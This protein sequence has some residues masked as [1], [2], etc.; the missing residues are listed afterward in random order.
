MDVYFSDSKKMLNC[1]IKNAYPYQ[2]TLKAAR[3]ISQWDQGGEWTQLGAIL[4]VKIAW[5]KILISL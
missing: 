3:F 1:V 5:T 2:K 4:L